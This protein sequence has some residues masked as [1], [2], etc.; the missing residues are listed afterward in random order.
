MTLLDGKEFSLN[1]KN[2]LKQKIEELKPTVPKLVI[3]QIGDDEA[4]SIYIERK[5]QFGESIG[6]N[7]EVIN[8]DQSVSAEEVIEKIKE[9]NNSTETHGIIVQLPIPESLSESKEKII[10]T[11]HPKK[12]VDG[13][14]ARN[15]W[16]LMDDKKGI[17]PATALGI[18]KLLKENGISL[19]G[20]HVVIVGD[21]LLVG[22][23]TAV[24]MLNSEATVTVCHDKTPNLSNFTKQA[25]IIITAVGK[26]NIINVE[27]VKEGQV[28]VD[29]GIRKNDEG[30]VV[31]DINFEEVKDI[32][33]FITPV[34]GGVGPVTVSSL[35]DNLVGVI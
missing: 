14:T 23:S 3:F 19:E 27:H 18:E 2:I 15:L 26:E 31:G 24:H 22:K 33:D 9:Q 28:L 10:N 7:V 20:K 30:K 1:Q 8:F 25:D 12:D 11:I 21:S 17:V 5:K 32:V 16:R 29:V 4:S 13:L 35:F 34:P 6:A